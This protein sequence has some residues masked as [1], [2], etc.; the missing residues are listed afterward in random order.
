MKFISTFCA[1]LLCTLCAT[2]QNTN[3]AAD[4]PGTLLYHTGDSTGYPYR[5]PAIA[6]AK[7]GDV[8]A[9][10]DW[11]PCGGDIGYGRV[12]IH[13]RILPN[14]KDAE[15]SKAFTI[16]AGTGKGADTG[17]G[18]AC[19]VADRDR[20]EMLLVCCGGDITYQRSTKDHHQ[21]MIVMHSKYNKRTKQWEWSQP[22]DITDQIYKELFGERIN[23]LFMGSGRICQSSVVKVGKYY[24][25]YGALCTHRGNFVIYSDDFGRNWKVLGDATQSCAPRG[26]EP[27]CEELPGGSVLLSSRKH[28]GRYFNVFHYTNTQKAEG[29]WGHPVDSRTAP[30]GI[31]NEGTPCNGEIFIVSAERQSD[32]QLTR[33]ALQSI[34]AGPGRSNVTIYWKELKQPSDYN[35]P[36]RF[37]SN[38]EG[39]YLVS[40][41]GS[42]YSTMTQLPSGRIG[43]F[44]EE[45]PKW[46]QMIYKELSIE[47]ITGGKFRAA[48]TED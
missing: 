6:T 21:R 17:F 14:A 36:M 37:A 26:D 23:G 48:A 1:L 28:G 12:D 40:K 15:W 9:I 47:D 3:G 46:Y 30:G 5:I 25:V 29:V 2:A 38:W 45:E 10:S 32:G 27:K 4:Q 34:P 16:I 13:G 18:D 43:F 35:T 42:A 22:L 33:V 41:L 44:Y 19:I 7:N 24:R 31:S 39:S 11:R 8:I 20:N